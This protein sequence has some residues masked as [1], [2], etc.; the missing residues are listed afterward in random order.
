MNK[1]FLIVSLLV[2]SACN[3]SHPEATTFV[4]T[5]VV[6]PPAIR[7]TRALSLTLPATLP[8]LGAAIIKDD[9]LE[10]ATLGV[11][12]FLEKA[13]FTQSD[14]FHLGSCTKAMTATLA[15]IL[16]EEGKFSWTSKV[17]DLIPQYDLHPELQAVTIEQLL[18]H[19]S[20][21]TSDGPE[22]FTE[23]W[24]YLKL[25]TT[26]MTAREARAYYAETTLAMKPL[27]VPGAK[28]RYHNGGYMILALIMEELTGQTWETLIQE[29][30]FDPLEMKTCGTG[31]TW[32]HIRS[33]DSTVPVKAD[34]PP[35]F[36]PASGVHCS[37]E[38]WGK[39][40]HEHL[41]G[42]KNEPGIVTSASFEK[43]HTVAANDGQNYT[44]GGWV[45]LERSW[46]DGPVLWH[47]GSN[48]WNYAQ[49]FIAPAKNAIV[50]SA[51]NIG[52]SEAEIATD[53]ALS[54]VIKS[55][56]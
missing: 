39:F 21:L 4:A 40:L 56:L 36:N 49:V 34:N 37:L 8:A 29:K 50:M 30:V 20:G 13:A 7:D 42:L 43:L 1:I 6:G 14:S 22:T 23:N 18:S 41:K 16:I 44:F 31:P 19:R 11:K 15:A 2:L 10:V 3:S 12:V 17:A 32:G 27:S 46:A 25:Q 45:K 51:T 47:N 33:G 53:N 5:T 35:A 55:R 38:D 28:F 48:T 26:S 54:E 52:G 24:L 9:Q